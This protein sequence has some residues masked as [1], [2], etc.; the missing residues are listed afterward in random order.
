M[1]RSQMGPIANDHKP[2]MHSKGEIVVQYIVCS[3]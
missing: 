3:T 1:L 2:G